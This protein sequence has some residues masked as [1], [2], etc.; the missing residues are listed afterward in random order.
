[1]ER[2]IIKQITDAYYRI[3]DK[4]DNHKWALDELNWLIYDVNRDR[5]NNLEWFEKEDVELVMNILRNK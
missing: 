4:H 5:Y 2:F 3:L 1:M